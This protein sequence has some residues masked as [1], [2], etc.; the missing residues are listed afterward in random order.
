MRKCSSEVAT[1]F[2]GGQG[3]IH[4]GWGVAIG[5]VVLNSIFGF[6]ECIGKRKNAEKGERRRKN[7]K[8]RE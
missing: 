2:M 7:R 1:T 4:G 5:A 8:K 3:H 6:S